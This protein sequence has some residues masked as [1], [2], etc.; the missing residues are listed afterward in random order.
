MMMKYDDDDD[1]D[2]D[3]DYDENFHAIDDYD[4]Y[5]KDEDDKD[6]DKK[7]NILGNDGWGPV[8]EET[9][10]GSQSTMD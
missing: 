3:D 2:D 1:D 4:Y 9:I 8:E 5:D 6:D 10:C 7:S